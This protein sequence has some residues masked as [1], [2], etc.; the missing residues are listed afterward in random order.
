VELKLVI[1]ASMA[2]FPCSGN[3][4]VAGLCVLSLQ[5]GVIAGIF[6][7]AFHDVVVEREMTFH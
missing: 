7:C 1:R 4:R 2:S 5:L 3:M 6:D